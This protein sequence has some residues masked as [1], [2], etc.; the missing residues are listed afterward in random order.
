VNWWARSLAKP[1]FQDAPSADRAPSD[2]GI[3]GQA[4]AGPL[5]GV[6]HL[7]HF[8]K[9]GA[10]HLHR[11]AWSPGWFWGYRLQA[12]RDADGAF[13]ITRNDFD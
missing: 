9:D 10:G 12:R 11:P 3:N 1:A 13:L 8:G 6:F 7:S 5:L 4:P 2:S